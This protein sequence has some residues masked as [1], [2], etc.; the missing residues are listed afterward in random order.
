MDRTHFPTKNYPAQIIN[1]AKIEKKKKSPVLS[2]NGSGLLKINSLHTC[3][4][5]LGCDLLPYGATENGLEGPGLASSGRMEVSL[6]L[7]Y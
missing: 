2:R 3:Y 6:S 4:S 5:V 7:I 1:S